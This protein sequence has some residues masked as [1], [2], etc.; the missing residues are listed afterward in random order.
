[1]GFDGT[2]GNKA[3]DY[4]NS[5]RTGMPAVNDGRERPVFLLSSG[6]PAPKAW[7]TV[8]WRSCGLGE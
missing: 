6:I 2:R 3:P 7:R 1:M 8:A 5:P 4:P